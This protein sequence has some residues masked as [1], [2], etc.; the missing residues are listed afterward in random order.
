MSTTPVVGPIHV[1]FLTLLEESYGTQGGY[2][3]T[4]S[5]GRPIE[6]RVSSAVQPNQVQRILYGPTLRDY[7]GAELIGKTL[8]EKSNGPVQLVITDSV[9]AL[10]VRQFVEI[11]VL[12]LAEVDSPEIAAMPPGRLIPLTHPPTG[13]M[14]FL[15]SR[16]QDD[17]ARVN[18]LLN[19]IDSSVD[20]S[21]PFARVREAMS[22]ARKMGVNNRAA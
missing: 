14:L 13:G 10:P 5:W 22:E 20:L 3:V 8:V 18:E 12:L 15:E 16:F 21:E 1:G 9:A 11:P 4:N 2:L 7:L 6:F 17:M 19:Q